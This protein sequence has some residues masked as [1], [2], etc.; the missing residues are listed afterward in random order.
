LLLGRGQALN[1]LPFA[2]LG[3]LCAVGGGVGVDEGGG[4]LGEVDGRAAPAG[5]R[6]GGGVR[7]EC[8]GRR[9]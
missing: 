9:R 4:P 7:A 2:S 1:P 5:S 3:A 6:W 8:G